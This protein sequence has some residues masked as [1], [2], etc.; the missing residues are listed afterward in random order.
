[1]PSFSRYKDL[2]GENTLG[3]ARKSQS[4]MLMEATWDRDIASRICYLYDWYRDDHKTQLNNLHP[5]TD[6]KKTPINL[7]YIVY[8]SQ[9]YDKD[10]VTYH[11]Q[12]KPSQ[13]PNVSYYDEL[14]KD[15]YDAEFPVGLYVDIPD[16][17]DVYN[18]WLV[19]DKANFNDPQFPTYEILRCDKVIQYIF[20]GKKYNVPAVLRS[21]NS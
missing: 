16:S 7:K 6:K 13:K 11:I 10:Q 19:V 17:K 9:T 8:S 4:D 1:M 20:E 21:Q 14:F 3:Q 5:Q 15:M 18:R 12:M 2:H